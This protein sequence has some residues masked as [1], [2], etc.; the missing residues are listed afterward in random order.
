MAFLRQGEMSMVVAKLWP[1]GAG[2]EMASVEPKKMLENK[3]G[4]CSE[5]P[6]AFQ[7]QMEQI[8]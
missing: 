8:D 5:S 1:A 3:L 4:K 7:E 6:G 2:T